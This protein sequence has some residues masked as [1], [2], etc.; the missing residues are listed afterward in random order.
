MGRGVRAGTGASKAEDFPREEVAR[1][2]VRR[3]IEEGLGARKAASD[4]DSDFE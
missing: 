1:E 3:M 4:E 2:M